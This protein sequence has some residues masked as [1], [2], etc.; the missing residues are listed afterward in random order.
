MHIFICRGYTVLFA[1]GHCHYFIVNLFYLQMTSSGSETYA[2]KNWNH[3]NNKFFFSETVHLVA[4][5]NT[6][7]ICKLQYN[8]PKKFTI[9]EHFHYKIYDKKQIQKPIYGKG[10]WSS[11]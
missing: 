8:Q 2:I 6:V 1:C 11:L 10:R 5:D 9:E 7:S 4:S 3:C